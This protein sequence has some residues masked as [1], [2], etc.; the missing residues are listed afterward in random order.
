M[1]HAEHV[2]WNRLSRRGDGQLL[3]DGAILA[4]ADDHFARH[5]IKRLVRAVDDQQAID[6]VPTTRRLV[7]RV[8]KHQCQR[9][10]HFGIVRAG[11]VSRIGNGSLAR[12]GLGGGDATVANRTSGTSLPGSHFEHFDGRARSPSSR[13]MK[14]SEFNSDFDKTGKMV[15]FLYRTGVPTKTARPG[16][17]FRKRPGFYPSRVRVSWDEPN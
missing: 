17:R 10:D 8:N 11:F 1:L 15:R 16:R 3:A 12:V 5:Q 14:R 13:V 7:L 9:S 4:A 2:D 6:L